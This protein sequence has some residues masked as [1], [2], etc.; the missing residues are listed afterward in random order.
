MSSI[1][2]GAPRTRFPRSLIIDVNEMKTRSTHKDGGLQ[3]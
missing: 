2:H 1:F 3:P